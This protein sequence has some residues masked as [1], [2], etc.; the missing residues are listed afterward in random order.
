MPKRQVT[1][2]PELASE[3]KS[4]VVIGV[5]QWADRRYSRGQRLSYLFSKVRTLPHNANRNEE[6]QE[7]AVDTV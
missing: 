6:D 3:A 5:P 7:E 4:I 2:D 1:L